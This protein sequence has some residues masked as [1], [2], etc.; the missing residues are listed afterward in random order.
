MTDTVLQSF[1]ERCGTRYTFTEQDTRRESGLSKLGRSLGLRGAPRPSGEPTVATALPTHDP[2][3]ATFHF[4]LECR[5]Y[6]CQSCW[7]ADA[8]Y[9][10]TCYPLP[11]VDLQAAERAASAEALSTGPAAFAATAAVVDSAWPTTDLDRASAA[12]PAPASAPRTVDDG[13][14]PWGPGLEATDAAAA[15]T[16]PFAAPTVADGDEGAEAAD[17]V[18]SEADPTAE[19]VDPWSGRESIAAAILRA[20]E[21]PSSAAPETPGAPATA[22]SSDASTDEGTSDHDATEEVDDDEP[23]DLVHDPWR[24]VVFSYDEADAPG[25]ATQPAWASAT[26]P[27]P[28]EPD[29]ALPLDPDLPWLAAAATAEVVEHVADEVAI[30]EAETSEDRSET[31]PRGDVKTAA[32][33]EPT[34]LDV[35]D[36]PSDEAAAPSDE[37]AADHG[38]PEAEDTRDVDHRGWIAASTIATGTGWST[39]MRPHEDE[40][41]SRT[42]GQPRHWM[43][44]A[45]TTPPSLRRTLRPPRL[46]SI[47]SS[48]RSSRP[49]SRSMPRRASCRMTTGS[50]PRPK[51]SPKPSPTRWSLTA[52]RSPGPPST[53]PPSPS[54]GRAPTPAHPP[55]RGPGR[56][57][58]R[59][60]PGRRARGRRHIRGRRSEGR[61]HPCCGGAVPRGAG[62]GRSDGAIRR[63]PRAGRCARAG[64]RTRAAQRADERTRARAMGAGPLGAVLGAPAF[65]DLAPR[66]ARAAAVGPARAA[67]RTDLRI[68]GTLRSDR[69]TERSVRAAAVRGRAPAPG[70]TVRRADPGTSDDAPRDHGRGAARPPAERAPGCGTPPA[71][72]TAAR[73][74]PAGRCV[75]PTASAH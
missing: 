67:V 46:K 6:T 55:T 69:A 8:G 60:R 9:C 30:T 22:S 44:L 13:P 33:D 41:P 57:P 58:G 62:G 14:S 32:A 63:A 59:R 66:A 39:P 49:R 37:A 10:Q 7:N 4:C 5:Q 17:A 25:T 50:R 24:G 18:A 45:P 68:G 54:R 16:E 38:S 64:R 47:R 11:E 40:D 56:S 20:A 36:A 35:A 28:A 71:R 21:A 52:R 19:V 12:P 51:P 2:F 31:W 74:P 42:P 34:D 26:Q 3:R 53:R 61:R 29:A 27:T 72:C 73:L 75:R 23:R 48:K 70:R 43:R 65:R 15:V 1:C